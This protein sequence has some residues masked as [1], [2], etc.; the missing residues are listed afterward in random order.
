MLQERVIGQ[1]VVPCDLCLCSEASL[2]PK[3]RYGASDL[4]MRAAVFIIKYQH[5][6]LAEIRDISFIVDASG[7]VSCTSSFAGSARCKVEIQFFLVYDAGKSP[8]KPL[9]FEKMLIF[10]KF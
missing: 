8:E 4:Q 10:S 2:L 1:I 6:S 3:N 9:F 5:L 7:I